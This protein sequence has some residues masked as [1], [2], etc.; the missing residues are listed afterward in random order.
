MRLSLLL[1]SALIV[2]PVVH[3]EDAPKPKTALV[4][5]GG[6]GVI[7][8]G[9]MTKEEEAEV[10]AALDKALDAGNAVLAKGGTALDAVEATIRILEDDP[11][12]NAGKG[13]VFNAEGKH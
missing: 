8:R 4:V 11:H 12:F 9:S 5:H 6:A 1:A 7:E 3:A 10:R 2:A 13:A